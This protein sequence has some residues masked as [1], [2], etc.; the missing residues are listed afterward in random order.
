[1][2]F[3]KLIIV[4]L[5][6][7]SF[8]QIAAWDFTG[9]NTV[10]T[11]TAEIY[12]ANLDASS[13][14][15]RGSGASASAGANSFRTVG[16]Q[17]NGIAVTNT[18]YFETTF[19]AAAGYTLSLTSINANFAGTGTFSATPGVQMQYACSLDG[20]TFTFIGSPFFKIGNGAMN[21]I[22]LS[23][24]TQLQNVPSNATVTIR[25][26]ASGQTPTG[27]WG[28]TSSALGIYGLQFGGS[29]NA[30]TCNTAAIISPVSCN[31]YT[32]PS[33]DETY[34]VSGTY[35]DTIP[36]AALCDSI[37]TINLTITAGSITY[38]ADTDNDGLGDLNNITTGCSLPLG[39]VTNSND[40]NDLNPA[41]GIASTIYYLDADN[42]T[43]GT[44]LTTI[45]A[46]SQPV[47]YVSNNLDCN[48]VDILIN[49]AATDIF[50]NGIDEDCS[51]SDASSLGSDIGMYQFT[52]VSACPVTALSVTTQPLNALFSNYSSSGVTC[53][54]AANVFSNSNWNLTSTLDLNEYNEFSITA[55]DCSSLDINRIIF[56]HRISSTGGTP[57]WTLRS[58]VDNFTSNLGIG[59]PLTTDRTD[60]VNLSSAFDALSQV[61]FRFY[62]TNMGGTGSTWRNDNVRIIANFGTQTPQT[63]YADSDNDN[64]GNPA[65]SILVCTPP[66]GYILNNTDCDDTDNLINPTTIWY[67]DTDGDLIGNTLVIIT[68][69]IQPA[70]YVLTPGD[71]N[72]NNNLI[73]SP[74]TYYLDADNDGHG[75][76]V[77]I[78]LISCT[79]PGAGYVTLSDDCNDANS[80]IYP[81]ATEICD[82]LDNDC[83]GLSDDGLIF[84][85]YFTDSDND[86][87]GTGTSILYCQ[88]PGIGFALIDGDCDDLNGAIG[89]AS[90]IY[91]LDSDNDTYGNPLISIVACIAPAGYVTNSLDCNDGDIL[92]NPA[93][94]DI[95]DNG[96]DEDCSGSDASAAGIAIGLYEFTDLGVCPVIADTVS[97]QPINAL[98]SNYSSIGTTCSSSANVFSNSNWNQ[99]GTLDL[100][101]YNE[102]SLTANDCST[103]DLNKIIFTHR[104]SASGGTPTWTLRSS[105]D[106]FVADLG[107]GTPLV[108]DNTDTVNLSAA[109]DALSQ[110]T[111]RF[112]ITNMGSSGAT[113]RNDNVSIIANFGTLIPQTYYADT[114]GD[115]F[116]DPLVSI[117]VCT[118]Q[119]GY[120]LDN[121]D[122]DDTDG[123]INPNTIWYQDNDGDLTGNSLVTLTQ[124]LQPIGYV[125]T[126]GD[127]D[128]NNNL[129]INPTTYYL[130]A[131]GDG[132]GSMTG[133]A[134]TSCTNPGMG[135]VTISDDC[136]DALNT[137]YP[138]APEICDQLDNNCNGPSDEGLIYNAYFT[139]TDNDTYGTGTGTL[140]CQDPGT[141]YS[142]IDGDC[143]DS[144]PNAYP[145]ATEILNNGID[146][147]CDGTD[148][149]LGTP[150][151]DNVIFTIQPNPSTGIFKVNFNQLITGRIECSDLNGKIVSSQ[152]I[153]NSF[154]VL[155]LTSISN[156]TYILKIISEN[157]IAQQ[158]IVI[159][160]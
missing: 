80:T 159:Q 148:N 133:L 94:F 61:T 76:M 149:Y 110:V 38:Y 113:W 126:P 122:C 18:D 59:T 121:T 106:N 17:N 112:Y 128:D 53:S 144:N 74:I 5:P 4:F 64:F 136:D 73:L 42:D 83:N 84:T 23:G 65:V 30:Q 89:L 124:C 9:E 37:L 147:N 142:L 97:I 13:T 120:I 41:I 82:G 48:D 66:N 132:H 1:M 79:N 26:Y 71:C 54:P 114:D 153:E 77:G 40:C 138:G 60:T 140:F 119:N 7:I 32:V 12:A 63:Y 108:N 6:F 36:N 91:Y 92:I 143:N 15:T 29:V 160:K 101:E 85:P 11:S 27:G 70:G 137:V 33:G 152:T 81:N 16:F 51:G 35:Y 31:S 50:D 104:I 44:P 117:S 158:R 131:D 88:N 100:N 25:L 69:C 52:Q 68:S 20:L 99:T 28:Y 72:D 150:E 115:N 21:Q 57:T 39:Y 24:I 22:D 139:D 45:I 78:P 43:Y 157:G 14:I 93:A 107:T 135:Y 49:P 56:T 118:T 134:I 130:D 58:S 19:S 10:A 62:I 34:T 2:N 75:S 125:L 98:F 67:Q 55:N 8:G 102:F 96:I 46:C 141:G 146:E 145:G 90:T 86:S 156:G 151:I 129:V 123:L 103:L 155:N 87:F 95:L 116:G 127:C 3:L 111:F 105:I 154:V 109:F 47:G